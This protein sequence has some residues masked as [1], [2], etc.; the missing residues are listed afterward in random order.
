M[1]EAGT[2]SG[3]H[4]TFQPVRFCYIVSSSREALD[5][6]L[7]RGPPFRTWRAAWTTHNTV[8][9]KA[10]HFL[11]HRFPQVLKNSGSR[12]GW[13]D[14]RYSRAYLIRPC[15][16]QM[17]YRKVLCETSTLQ[18][19]GMNARSGLAQPTCFIFLLPHT[20]FPLI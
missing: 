12:G 8:L 19:G 17:G 7:Q 5:S 18:L 2:I 11:Y 16:Y 20:C 15:E 14:C 1:A 6:R 3:G 4:G 9:G 13:G 10:S